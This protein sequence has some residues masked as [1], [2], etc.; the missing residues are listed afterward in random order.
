MKFNLTTSIFGIGLAVFA[1]ALVPGVAAQD[2][3]YF[4]QSYEPSYDYSGEEPEWETV[5]SSSWLSWG[6]TEEAGNDVIGNYTVEPYD[7]QVDPDTREVTGALVKVHDGSGVEVASGFHIDGRTS[8]YINYRDEVRIKIED[9]R[10]SGGG[11]S[12]WGEEVKPQAKITVQQR[13]LPEASV[14]DLKVYDTHELESTVNRSFASSNVWTST[15]FENTGDATLYDAEFRIDVANLTVEEVHDAKG[16][17]G[18][19]LYTV[20]DGTLTVDYGDVEPR[21]QNSSDWLTPG[22]TYKLDVK[23]RTPSI[24]EER[25]YNFTTSLTGVDLKANR[26]EDD[27]SVPFTVYSTVYVEKDLRPD[28]NE[29]TEGREMYL[30]KEF[31][32][33]I[34]VRNFAD[35]PVTVH[36][37]EDTVP[38]IFAL[39]PNSTTEWTDLEVPA[40]DN[41]VLTYKVIPRDTGEV[42]IPDPVTN[43]TWKGEEVDP[44]TDVAV[45]EIVVEKGSVHGPVLD[46]TKSVSPGNLDVGDE[47]EVTIEVENTGDRAARIHLREQSPEGL[48]PLD[49]VPQINTVLDGGSSLSTGYRFRAMEGGNYTLAPTRVT[50][51]DVFSN[52]WKT[53]SKEANVSVAG[54]APTAEETETNE[55]ENGTAP[56][57]ASS[58]DSTNSSTNAST[59]SS[60]DG[61]LIPNIGLPDV[62]GMIGGLAE[63]LRGLVPI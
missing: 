40:G 54:D 49:T 27:A 24:L 26:F 52:S 1:L 6:D 33:L 41:V 28:M 37:I 47:G 48:L 39:A 8:P 4:P 23:L 12:Q 35:A 2:T 55:E 44:S 61:G 32:M 19:S 29:E 9:V 58:D 31:T 43:L 57:N 56:I 22:E 53:A 7:F 36:R 62:G 51:R 20:E 18:P 5:V 15:A 25:T 60:D 38:D 21:V 3:A 63:T 17:L 46:V 42:D 59:N 16:R 45:D 30:G 10:D 34:S 11:G 13:K 50:Y 14:E